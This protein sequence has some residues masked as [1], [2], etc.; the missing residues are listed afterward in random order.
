MKYDFIIVGAGIVGLA[1]A[2]KLSRRFPDKKILIIE[3]ENKPAV[4]QTGN[5]SGV[6]HSGIYYKPGSYKAQTCTQGRR[7]LL[8]FCREHDI[9][10]KICGK[11][12]V[13]ASSEEL[14]R[15]HTLCERGKKNGLQ[16]LTY[17]TQ[18]QLGEIEPSAKCVKALWVPETGIVDFTAVCIKL[19]DILLKAG[20]DFKF[21]SRVLKIESTQ[22]DL[23]VVTNEEVFHSE[24]FINCAGL[25]ADRV[26]EAAGAKPE[27]RIIPFRGEYYC[28]KDSAREL[29]K[30]LIYPV[31]DLDFPFLGVHF[32]RNI[33]GEVECGPNAV[34]ALKREG[35]KKSSF[36]LKDTWDTLT[37]PGFL[38]LAV[39]N[40]KMGLGEMLRS[41]SKKAFLKGLQRLIPAIQADDIIPAGAGVRANAVNSKGKVLDDFYILKGYRQ[42]H[43]L[44]APSPAATAALALADEIVR[45]AAE[46]FQINPY[47]Y[48]AQPN[49]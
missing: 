33:S 20:A 27:I 45:I 34:L 17:L 12:V 19:K 35:Y 37:Y 31:P 26:A 30:G 23:I 43:V 1:T 29:V 21:N 16:G 44:N 7:Q 15:L 13:A 25:H 8:N 11:V 4:H 18:E 3:K 38:K 9:P 2:Y 47:A 32:T 6:I 36:N 46:H 39:S 14:P 22:D 28:L 40:L 41:Y 24:Y 49:T 5:N 42:V 10:F 48:R